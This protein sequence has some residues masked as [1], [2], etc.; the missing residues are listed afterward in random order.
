MP[1]ARTIARHKPQCGVTRTPEQTGIAWS[2]SACF[3][4]AYAVNASSASL[5]EHSR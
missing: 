2:S 5:G 1:S 4:R 3:E